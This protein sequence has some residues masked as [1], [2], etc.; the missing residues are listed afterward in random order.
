MHSASIVYELP[1]H[2]FLHGAATAFQSSGSLS[3]MCSQH[4]QFVLSH[5]S[6]THMV[7]PVPW[8]GE[9]SGSCDLYAAG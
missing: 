9:W 4:D 2:S 6:P 8:N 3:W 5:V 1:R 7:M